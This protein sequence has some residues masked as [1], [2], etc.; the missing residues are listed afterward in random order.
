MRTALVAGV[1]ALLAA[2]PTPRSAT[3]SSATTPVA[4]SMVALQE[5]TTPGRAGWFYTLDPSEASSAVS[6]FKFTKSANI[7]SMHRNSVP[8]S[9][10]V[11]RL[12]SKSAASYLLSISP[13]EIHG[14][15]FVDEGVL[16]YVDRE[17]KPGEVPL[18]RFSNH[19]KWRVLADGTANVS[20]MK[21]E[22]YTVDGPL[23]YFRP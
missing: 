6:K 3:V 22:G 4:D 18:V 23:G 10:A 5:F 12:R 17:K 1:I 21:N 11:H 20:N 7:G 2:T 9:V 16:G 19:G 8:G 15:Q 13:S 14:G